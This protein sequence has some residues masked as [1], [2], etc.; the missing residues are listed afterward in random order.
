MDITFI[1]AI[2]ALIFGVL[3]LWNRGLTGILTGTFLVIVGI[4]GTIGKHFI[5]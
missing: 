1:I 4:L 2:I 5:H 3:I